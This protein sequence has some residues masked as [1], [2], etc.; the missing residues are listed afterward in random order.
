VNDGGGRVSGAIADIG[1]I[2]RQYN[3][4]V[5]DGF[6]DEVE[7]VI[8]Y[9]LGHFFDLGQ[10]VAREMMTDLKSEMG[11]ME[12]KIDMMIVDAKA[13]RREIEILRAKL[14]SRDGPK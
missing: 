3:C 2:M 13:D 7:R 6:P 1:H 9:Q 5:G 8:A 11:R 10:L 14:E 12:A 4:L